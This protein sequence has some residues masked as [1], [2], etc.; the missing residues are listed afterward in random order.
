MQENASL[1]TVL[2]CCSSFCT[3]AV[4]YASKSSLNEMVKTRSQQK[5]PFPKRKTKLER[6]SLS[7][8]LDGES[9]AKSCCIASLARVCREKPK[10]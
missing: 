3:L 2:L 7:K 5:I 1:N 6:K 4:A 9:K 10:G 8:S